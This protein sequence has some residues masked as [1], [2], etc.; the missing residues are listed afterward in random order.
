MTRYAHLKRLGPLAGLMAAAVVALSAMPAGATIVCPPGVTPPNP[1]CTNVPPI[2]IT[3]DA[4]NVTGTSATL[5][6]TT[7][8]GVAGGDPTQWFF[9]YGTT[10]AYGQ[11]TAPQTLGSCPPGVNPPSPYCTTPASQDVSAGI[12]HLTPCTLYDFRIVASNPDGTTTGA[13]KS[14]TTGFA[15]PIHKVRVSPHRV[16]GGHRFKVKITLDFRAHVFIFLRRH[17]HNV[18]SFDLGFV[19]P[20]K[21][22]KRIRA[23]HKTGK[24][25]VRVVASLSCGHQTVDKKLFVH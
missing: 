22:T 3:K 24:Y 11:A 12:S 9:Q 18:K 8:A 7:G 20:G 10:T 19:G 14:F 21:V 17:H 2:A 5:N 16:K 13:N 4:T 1:Y 23:P 15:H 6:G 25:I